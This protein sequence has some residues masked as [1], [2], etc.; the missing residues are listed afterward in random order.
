MKQCKRCNSQAINPH[1]HGR[2][3][4]VDLNL[5]DVCYWRKRAEVQSDTLLQNALVV[6]ATAYCVA[7]EHEESPTVQQKYLAYTVN[8]HLG[9]DRIEKSVDY[10]DECMKRFLND[11]SK[12]AKAFRIDADLDENG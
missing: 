3:K 8:T 5:C 4:D 11:T 1:T 9:R 7:I 12:W 10:V 2:Q 6:A